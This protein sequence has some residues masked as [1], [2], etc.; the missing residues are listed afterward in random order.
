MRFDGAA[1]IT[2]STP[3][4]KIA[5]TGKNLDN[6]IDYL[7]EHRLVWVKEPD[8]DFPQAGQ[9]EAIIEKIEIE[10]T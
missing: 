6:I 7:A 3:T 2:L 10:E 5:I 8:S 1:K 4:L 9:G